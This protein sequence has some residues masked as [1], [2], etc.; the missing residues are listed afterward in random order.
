MNNIILAHGVTR[1]CYGE[2]F[3]VDVGFKGFGFEI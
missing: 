1:F 3:I 2:L